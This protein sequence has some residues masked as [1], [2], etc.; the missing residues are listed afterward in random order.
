MTQTWVSRLKGNTTYLFMTFEM[1]IE[2]FN[3]CTWVSTDIEPS[4][5]TF[6]GTNR[7]TRLIRLKPATHCHEN[8]LYHC[9]QHLSKSETFILRRTLFISSF[10][11]TS[12]SFVTTWWGALAMQSTS[13]H[14]NLLETK[15]MPRRFLVH[16]IFVANFTQLPTISSNRSLNSVPIRMNCNGFGDHFELALR[17]TQNL[18]SSVLWFMIKTTEIPILLRYDNCHIS[19][20][21]II[22]YSYIDTDQS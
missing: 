4:L 16:Y 5:R 9:N 7:A 13:N 11:C 21:S 10:D 3:R 1:Q 6:R 8:R 19:G 14:S 12:Q 20:V 17:S 2:F 15:A 22:T 18:N